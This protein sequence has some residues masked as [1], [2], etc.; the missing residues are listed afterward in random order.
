[1]AQSGNS[2]DWVIDSGASAHITKS[3]SNLRN[4]REPASKEIVVGD[5]GRLEVKCA[6]DMHV[7]IAANGESNGEQ[8][9]VKNVLCV[10]NI[11]ANLMSVSQMAKHGKTLVFDKHSCRIFD[12]NADLMVTAP[13]VDN[14]HRLNCASD[15]KATA[16]AASTDINLWH[17]RRA[18]ACNPIGHG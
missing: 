1:M 14:L 5:N 2:N 16:F 15:K 11:C 8:V 4:L 13:L 18:H 6:G 17:R 12:E 9:T 3:E 7:A 10:P